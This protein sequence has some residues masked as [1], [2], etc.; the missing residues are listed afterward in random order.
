MAER[1]FNKETKNLVRVKINS[2]PDFR[3]GGTPIWSVPPGSPNPNP[4]SDQKMSFVT[5]AFQTW[6]LKNYFIT[7]LD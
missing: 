2:G 4:I 6:P 3:G 7:Y 1:Q 5:P